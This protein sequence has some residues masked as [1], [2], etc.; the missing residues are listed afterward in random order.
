MR[1]SV[2]YL[3]SSLSLAA[4]LFQGCEGLVNIDEVT[5]INTEVTVAP[6]T[7]VTVL[8]EKSFTLKD[9][10]TSGADG[11]LTVTSEG[12]YKISYNLEPQ[13]IGDGFSF[14]ASKFA[15]NV[16]NSFNQSMSLSQAT[17]PAKTPISYNE[18]DKTAVEAYFSTFA[19]G[20]DIA[21]FESLLSQNYKFN[22]DI[23]FSIPGFPE[24]I[25]T[26]KKAD[27][28]G[29][30]TFNLVPAGIPFQKFIFK[31]GTRIVLP[32]FLKFSSCNNAD[33]TLQNGNLLVANKDVD[34]PMGTGLS[35]TLALQALDMGDG[36][37]TNGSLAL[38]G[39]VAV[40]GTISIN[41]E[42]FNGETIEVDLASYPAIAVLLTGEGS[43]KIVM[44]KE[45]TALGNFTVSCAYSA[46]NV[47]L[48][49]ATVQLSKDAIP[50]FDGNFGF[51]VGGLPEFLSGSDAN[52][53]LAEVKVVMDVNNGLPFGF[54]LSANLVAL[55]GS[56]VNHDVKIGPLD[57]PASKETIHTVDNPE[58]GKILSPIPTRIEARNF[59]IVF[60]DSQW[61]TAE[62]G[63]NY[64]G[65]FAVGFEAPISFTANTRL[66]LGIDESFDVDLGK[67][68]DIIKGE[69]P[70]EIR[71][72]AINS[73]P[74]NF[75]IEVEALDASKKAIPGV[76]GKFDKVA[77]GS[78]KN[79]AT[80]EVSISF[81]LPSDSKIIK[82]IGLKMNAYSDDSCA[83]ERLNQNQSVTVK[84]VT[85]KLPKG[86]TT[87]LKDII[88]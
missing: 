17:I 37:A 50:S 38:V 82:G 55:S 44:V 47:A 86:I 52:V 34:V 74:L 57:F 39:N 59:D 4:F 26:F 81:T 24:L 3:L 62:A 45:D 76:T 21:F 58:L 61:I 31:Q 72:T 29:N 19:S 85:L 80:T 22:F 40:D 28:E 33:F 53:E 30:F 63:K 25:K 83:G 56:T 18:A 67:T 23:D 2:F 71:F 65:T 87:D 68:G 35:F 51:D 49:N 15:L 69:T 13:S 32:S 66:S 46:A 5:D 79:P 6:G 88:K 48:K 7:E 16:N 12:E 73:I 60:D 42:D 41:P 10:V 70:V 64:S 43:H 8:S 27:L 9:L 75:G 36:V 78:L 20:V 1:K 77:A 14:D 54:G 84:G 11:K